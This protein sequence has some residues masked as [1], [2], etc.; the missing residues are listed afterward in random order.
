MAKQTGLTIAQQTVYKIITE[1]ATDGIYTQ[2]ASHLAF[3]SDMN[4]RE[5]MAAV[6]G[7]VEMGKLAFAGGDLMVTT[8]QPYIDSI[9][10]FARDNMASPEY[11]T[12]R[13]EMDEITSRYDRNRQRPGRGDY[14]TVAGTPRW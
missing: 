6:K 5:V 9:R 13:E 8:D 1:S 2:T 10:K 3:Q 4:K 12:H 14:G 11:R 7:L